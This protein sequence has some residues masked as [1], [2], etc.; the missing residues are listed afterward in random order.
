MFCVGAVIFLERG[1]DETGAGTGARKERVD[2]VFT[3][4]VFAGKEGASGTRVGVVETGAGKR[5][6]GVDV[7]FTGVVFAG[8]GGVDETGVGKGG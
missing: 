7:I 3:G 2:V 4:V 1:V 8:K 6:E 5:R